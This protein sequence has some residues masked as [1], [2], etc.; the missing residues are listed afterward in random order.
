MRREGGLHTRTA[1]LRAK[2]SDRDGVG[3][4][5]RAETYFEKGVETAAVQLVFPGRR[6]A[7]RGHRDLLDKR[8]SFLPVPIAT[9]LRNTW[10]P[11]VY[12]PQEVE[13]QQVNKGGVS[14]A[15]GCFSMDMS[16]GI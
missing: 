6:Q 12:A 2:R 7:K 8:T 3:K 10:P 1:R 9:A 4:E 13:D 11:V 14:L 16:G 5:G 15:P